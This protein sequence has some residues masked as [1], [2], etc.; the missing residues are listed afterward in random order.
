MVEQVLIRTKRL[1]RDGSVKNTY[2]GYYDSIICM[3]EL[4]RNICVNLHID[5]DTHDGIT[6]NIVIFLVNPL[7]NK[8]VSFTYNPTQSIGV[9]FVNQHAVSFEITCTDDL[10]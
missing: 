5:P 1:N 4:I 10:G 2:E 9:Q 8:K 7:N 6:R 3:G